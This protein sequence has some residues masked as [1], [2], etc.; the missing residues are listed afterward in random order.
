MMENQH[1]RYRSL[2]VEGKLNEIAMEVNEEAHEMIDSI[3]K[4]YFENISCK[5]LST[6]EM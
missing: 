3:E 2:M 5:I 4:I 6:I 1:V